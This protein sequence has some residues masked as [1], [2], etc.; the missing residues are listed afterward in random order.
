MRMNAYYYSFEPT[1][2]KEIDV[3]LSAIACAGK[4]YHNTADWQLDSFLYEDVHRGRTPIEWI[5]NAAN[6]AASAFKA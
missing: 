1:G 5:Q 4:A 3:L 6:D 2:V